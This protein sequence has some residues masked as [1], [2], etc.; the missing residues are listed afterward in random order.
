MRLPRI[1][2][3]GPFAIGSVA[4]LLVLAAMMA[5]PSAFTRRDPNA[6]DFLARLKPPS[7]AH[8][9]GTDENGR[10]LWARVVYGARPTIAAAVLLITV[11]AAVGGLAGLVIGSS[12]RRADEWLMRVTEFF[13]A[14]PQ[15][16]WALAFATVMGRGMVNCAIALVITWWAQYARLMRGQVLVQREKEFILTA[17]ALG[18]RQWRILLFHLLPNCLSP[19]L[20][21]ATIDVSLAI[22]LL[23]ALSFLG[24]GAQPPLPEWGAMVT[25]GRKYLLDYPWY[26]TFPG[27]AIFI[28]VLAFNV[29]GER[30]RDVLDPQSR[31]GEVP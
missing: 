21:K 26:A 18:Q 20:V 31:A 28:T 9:F 11:A 23:A 5:A 24:V 4:V 8:P 25:I 30:V 29:L 13:L 2:R 27:L 19:V 16:I 6:I 12:G 10:D 14:F 1:L 17:R 3:G 7:L 15:I 22:L